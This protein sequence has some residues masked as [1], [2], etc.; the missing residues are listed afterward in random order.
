M[1]TTTV[2]PNSSRSRLSA[3]QHRLLVA[4]V[5]LGGRLVGEDQRRLSRRRRRDRESLLLA[6][7]ERRRTL[8][9][10]PLQAE[11]IE[12]P[13]GRTRDVPAPAGEAQP[14]LDVLPCAQLVPQVPALEH[15]RDLPG[16]VACELGLVES[17]QGPSE[18]AHLARGRLVEPG[19]QMQRRALPR[20]RRPVKRDEL[21]RLDPQLEAA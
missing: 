12:R 8:R 3:P 2:L 19:R 11:R 16:A 9:L 7:G 6:S 15:D 14:E 4:I 1:T 5:E 21:A 18:G 17:G 10:A 13:V 20:P